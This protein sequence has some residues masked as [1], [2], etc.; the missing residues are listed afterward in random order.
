MDA[1][2]AVVLV[3]GLW[4]GNVTLVPL[5]RRLR[6]AGYR[7]FPYSYPSV[8]L[9]LHANARRLQRTLERVP[10][11]T[12]HFVAFSLGGLVLKALFHDYPSQRPGR[13]V[14][15]GS[16]QQG[17]VVGAQILRTAFGRLVGG[18]SLS[19]LVAGA[20]QG[21]RWPDRD[22]GVIAGSRALGLGGLVTRLPARPS[23]GSVLV[24]ET[25]V[26]GA[27]DRLVVPVAHSGLLLSAQVSEQVIRFLRAGRFARSAG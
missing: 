3:N 16:P 14:L 26:P 9:D 7:A 27:R 12:V 5:A 1:R 17:S 2:E 18:R 11:E 20:P 24:E 23:D 10:G 13:V 4:F 6:H 15:L 22:I 8:R 25:V 21:W 19:D